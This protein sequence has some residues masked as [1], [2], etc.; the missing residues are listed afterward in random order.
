MF[1]SL[2]LN[3]LQTENTTLRWQTPSGQQQLQVP[4]GRHPPRGG[5][6]M[7]MY[8][9]G[10]SLRQYPHPVQTARHE[11]GVVLQPFPTNVSA[12]S[13]LVKLECPYKTKIMMPGL[14]LVLVFHID[15][16]K[17]G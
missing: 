1:C 15:I 16:Y 6:A 14:G 2:Q 5:R 13:Q 4:F 3:S 10:S 9:T 12:E 17:D 7:S 8:E 11:D